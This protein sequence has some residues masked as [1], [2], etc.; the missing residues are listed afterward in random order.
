MSITPPRSG[1]RILV[2]MPLFL[3]CG[4]ASSRAGEGRDEPR[5]GYCIPLVDLAG[6]THR[7]IIV[8]RNPREYLGHPTT[9]LL[10]D[11]QPARPSVRFSRREPLA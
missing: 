9:V 5:R 2:Y 11:N 4:V 8:H 7:Q 10:E 6:E 3:F 1:I